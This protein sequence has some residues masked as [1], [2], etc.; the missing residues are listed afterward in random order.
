VVAGGRL[1]LR[2]QGTLSD[3]KIKAATPS[4]A[5]GEPR[6]NLKNPDCAVLHW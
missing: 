5:V 4:S 1:Y 3:Y 6:R 2:N